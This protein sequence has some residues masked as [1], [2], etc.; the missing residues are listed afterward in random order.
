LDTFIVEDRLIKPEVSWRWERQTE[1][2]SGTI[3]WICYSWNGRR[4]MVKI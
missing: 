1:L 4:R 2:L 3:K